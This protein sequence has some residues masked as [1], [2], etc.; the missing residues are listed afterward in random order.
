LHLS[1]FEA[2]LETGVVR[3]DDTKIEIVDRLFV[4][5]RHPLKVGKLF[6]DK[7][8]DATLAGWL[9]EHG[10]RGADLRFI[11]LF[12]R[13]DILNAERD[14]MGDVTPAFKDLYL[15]LD[16]QAQAARGNAI[17][18]LTVNLSLSVRRALDRL[19]RAR[20][21]SGGGRRASPRRTWKP[22]RSP[23]RSNPA[24]ATPISE[25]VK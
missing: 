6:S 5:V 9:E 16:A 17:G 7:M 14:E 25:S 19:A 10:S 15:R 3:E 4:F 21:V 23:E 18:V 20:G 2:G 1:L 22:A 8:E 11:H 13:V 12:E 24:P